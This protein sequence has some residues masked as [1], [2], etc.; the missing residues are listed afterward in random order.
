MTRLLLCTA[1][2]LA[3]TA[4]AKAQYFM[5]GGNS[6]STHAHHIGQNYGGYPAYYPAST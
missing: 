5:G 2:I 4:P 6:P 3:L 1:T